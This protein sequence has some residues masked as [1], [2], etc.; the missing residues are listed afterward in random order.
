MAFEALKQ[1]QSVMWG[2]GPY[3]R[4]TET[5]GDLHGLVIARLDPHS[6]DRWLD[7]ACGTGA[8]S[9]RAARAGAEV[10][11]VDLAPVLIE[12]ARERAKEQ[13]LKIDYQVGDCERLEGIDDATFDKL[14]S[15]CGI[16]F[17]PDHEA[18]A[19]ELARVVR[20]GG[21]IALANWTP[22]GGLGRMFR[23]MAPFQPGPPPS[24]P[25][26]WG[27]EDRVREL[28][29]ETFELEIEQHVSTLE[30]ADGEEYWQ[31]FS[32]SYGPT[33]TLAE[34]LAE[35]RRAEFHRAWVD[36]FEGDYRDGDHIA[37]RREYLLILGTRR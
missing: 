33:K 15:T 29:G 24:S 8:V 31:L 14:S 34:S 26:D 18:T 37:H 3:Q 25:F 12:T 7:L 10:V 36:F 2:N 4:V 17:A 20:R 23:M 5:L 22:E 32:T 6:G 16:M 1:R 30:T 19:R 21:R 11:G 28:L 35:E 27:R 9:E 13:Q